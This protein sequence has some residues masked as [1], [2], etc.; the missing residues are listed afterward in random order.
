MLNLGLG[1]VNTTTLLASLKWQPRVY[2]QNRC[3]EW[4]LLAPLV[5]GLQIRDRLL[6]LFCY[7][8]RDGWDHRVWNKR[9]QVCG[10]PWFGTRRLVCT[11]ACQQKRTLRRH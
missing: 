7:N 6:A 10:C 9:A 8:P 3:A 5:P 11:S 4:L 2:E 1:S